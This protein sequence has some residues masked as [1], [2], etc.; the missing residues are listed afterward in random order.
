MAVTY[1]AINKVVNFSVDGSAVQPR[2][3]VVDINNCNQCHTMLSV[4][5]TL[6]NQTQY[7]V[8]CHNPSNTDVRQRVN[9]MNP[10][11]KALPPQG[12]AF[13]LMV[14]RIH[15]SENLK[16]ENKSYTIVG[17]G[18]SHND[19][20][21]VHYPAMSPQGTTDDPRNCSMCHVN[22]SEQNLPTGLNAVTDPQG[23]LD[24]VQ[25]VTA[26]CTAC[27]VKI[28]TASHALANTTRLGESCEVCHGQS[29]EFNVAKVHAQY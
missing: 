14:H 9:A 28:T 24:P 4:H 13:D 23:P 22:G 3:M 29:G 19:F 6:R 1:G 26:A 17:F 25:P 16:A 15:T 8:L 10:A 12:I 18:G 2:R 20:N 5:G 7:C 21:D 27:H 11:D